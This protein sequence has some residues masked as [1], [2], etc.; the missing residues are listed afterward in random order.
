[1]C[2]FSRS[3][4]YSV[5]QDITWSTLVHRRRKIGQEFRYRQPLRWALPLILVHL[6]IPSFSFFRCLINPYIIQSPEHT[7][8]F[9]HPCCLTSPYAWY[10]TDYTRSSATAEWQRVSYTR[11]SAWSLIVHFTEH[12]ICVLIQLYNRLS[13][14]VSTLSANKPCDIRSRWSFQTLHTFKVICFCITRKPLRAFIF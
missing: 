13:K 12:R 7:V 1:M 9:V 10:W 6:F 4:C 3:F 5:T 8:G 2:H 14:L 11:L